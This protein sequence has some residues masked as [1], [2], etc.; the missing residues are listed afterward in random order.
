MSQGARSP[1]SQ[2]TSRTESIPSEAQSAEIL[3]VINPTMGEVAE[4]A[5]SRA[6]RALKEEGGTSNS[7]ITTRVELA[8]KT[9]VITQANMYGCRNGAK[10]N[11]LKYYSYSTFIHSYSPFVYS[12]ST[13]VHSYSA[14]VYS[15]STFVYS[16]LTFV[17]SHSA[18]VYSY[19]AFV[20]SYSTFVYSHSTFVCIQ[21]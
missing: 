3:Q 10:F 18:F 4:A 14:F 8:A 20:Y 13:F 2:L 7:M 6:I 21:Y 5:A 9:G 19:S 12:H 11:I 16:Y 17:Y 15:Y 1:S